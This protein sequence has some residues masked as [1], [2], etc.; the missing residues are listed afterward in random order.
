MWRYREALK[1]LDFFS[2]FRKCWI[3][4]SASPSQITYLYFIVVAFF[5]TRFAFFTSATKET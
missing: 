5:T 2:F 3:E 1:W 4:F